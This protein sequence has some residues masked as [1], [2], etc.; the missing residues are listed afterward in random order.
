[1][2]WADE[3]YVRLY[4]RDTTAW[5]AMVWQARALLP[6]LMRKLDRSGVLELGRHGVRGLAGLVG[7]PPEVTEPGLADLLADGCVIRRGDTLIMPNFQDAQEARQSDRLRKQEERSRRR[8]RALTGEHT[9]IEA[10][11]AGQGVTKRDSESQNVTNSHT[12]SHGVTPSHSYLSLA[13]LSIAKKETP[14][15][16]PAEPRLSVVSAPKPK[17]PSVLERHRAVAVEVWAYQDACRRKAIPNAR[18]LK[19][20]D[21]ALE[22]VAK[23]LEAGYTLEDCKHVLD[24]QVAEAQR[25]P[26]SQQWLNGVTPWRPEN[27]DRYLGKQAARAS[28]QQ[29][30]SLA[31]LRERYA[32]WDEPSE[33]AG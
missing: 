25:D 5:A 33:G 14:D 29:R 22:R 23:R 1:V 3:P 18:A 11:E 13:E 21:D 4:I 12:A 17:K 16:A 10:E 31:A 8:A 9:V 27:F 6:L 15:K 26:A 30:D 24:V 19:A 7:L 2:N 28:P 20:T 32:D